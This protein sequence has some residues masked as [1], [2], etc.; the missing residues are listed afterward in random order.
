MPVFARAVT[1]AGPY[2][3]GPH[4][5]GGPVAFG[6]VPVLP[7]D[8]IVGDSDGVVVIPREQ[9]AA[10]ADAA[11]AVFADETNRRASI[12]AARGQQ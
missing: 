5:L 1:P 3:D 7:G 10:V 9:A 11:E 4:R 12:V 2:K 6:G 8:I